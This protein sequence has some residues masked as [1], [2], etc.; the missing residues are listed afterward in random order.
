[1]ICLNCE[2]LMISDLAE[3]YIKKNNIKD[4]LVVFCNSAEDGGNQFYKS[5]KHDSHD[6][7]FQDCLIISGE[8]NELSEIIHRFYAKEPYIQQYHNGEFYGENT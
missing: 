2:P 7:I 3:F 5:I 6:F 1:M 8:R 4:A